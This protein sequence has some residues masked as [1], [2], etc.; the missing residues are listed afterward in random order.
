M[1][2]TI[3][4]KFKKQFLKVFKEKLK[5]LFGIYG[6]LKYSGNYWKARFLTVKEKLEKKFDKI[7]R[8]K[9][10]KSILVLNQ[11]ASQ[12][13]ILFKNTRFEI[14]FQPFF[15]LQGTAVLIFTIAL[16]FTGYFILTPTP[17][18]ADSQ[19]IKTATTHQTSKAISGKEVS[20]SIIVKKSDIKGNQ[21]YI[22]LPKTAT[23]IKVKTI[24][25]QQA[26]EILNID[27]KNP[28]N[29]LTLKERQKFARISPRMYGFLADLQET[30]KE[31][32]QSVAE[33]I[34]DAVSEAS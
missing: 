2:E 31:A 32:V 28:Q 34:T 16:L 25:Q 14:S 24:T 12:E 15:A 17:Q 4:Q 30:A 11:K 10:E 19:L 8:R 33:T 20:Y 18:I 26:E 7:R 29:H 27:T 3:W 5:F 23:N 6:I 22:K 13:K 21:T 1:K 9:I